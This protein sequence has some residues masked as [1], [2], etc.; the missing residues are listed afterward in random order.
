VQS[1]DVVAIEMEKIHDV[2]VVPLDGRRA[3]P[4]SFTHYLGDARGRWEGD[5]LV[6]ETANFP[7][8]GNYMGGCSGSPTR[9]LKLTETLHPR[10]RDTMR[11]E[12]TVNDPTVWTH[13]GRRPSIGSARRARS[14]S[15]PATRGTTACAA[16]CPAPAPTTGR[17][18]A[19]IRRG[20]WSDPTRCAA[21]AV[22]VCTGFP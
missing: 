3:L 7:S 15:T 18:R 6:V 10:G 12:F 8:G 9:N 20:R 22:S 16:C 5:T 2:R 17:G 4:L 19:K 13:R 14:T 1:P 11:Y 21:T